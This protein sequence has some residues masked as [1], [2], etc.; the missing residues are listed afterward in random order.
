MFEFRLSRDSDPAIYHL[1]GEIVSDAD[2]DVLNESFA[3]IQPDDHLIVDL[4][5]LAD[6]TPGAAVLLHELLMSRAALA[7]SVVVSSRE[8]VSMQLV[9]HDIDRVCPIV[10]TIEDAVSILDRPWA[11]RRL[12]H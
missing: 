10:T 8:D 6:L 9:L 1:S 5:D 4:R 11:R 2:I 7:E 12:P 3:F